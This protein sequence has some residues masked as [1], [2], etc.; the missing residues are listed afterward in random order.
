MQKN[1][2]IVLGIF[3]ILAVVLVFFQ[4]QQQNANG[5][6]ETTPLENTLEKN[7]STP[8]PADEEAPLSFE[9]KAWKQRI[10]AAFAPFNCPELLPREYPGGYYTGPL[11]DTH[12]HIPN[13]PD[14]PPEA[15]MEELRQTDRPS[16]GVNITMTEIECTLEN[17][18]TQK[19]IAF[20]PV[21]PEIPTQMVEVVNQTMQRY[22]EKFVPFIMPPAS[23][24]KPDGSPTVKAEVLADMLAIYPGLFK[25]YGEI[26]LY[27]RQGGGSKELPPDNPVLL[28]IYP[29][30]QNEKLLVYF[31]PGDGHADNLA[32][33]LDK[34]P[35]IIFLVHGD[36]IQPGIIDLMDK[37]PNVY[38]TMNDLYGDEWLLR[39]QV[40]KQEFL[41]YFSYYEPLIQKDL[42]MYEEMIEKHPDRFMWG[43]DR[44]DTL[45][46][47]DI[48]VG[49][50]LADY[51]RA[52]IGRLDPEIQEKF[53]YKNAERFLQQN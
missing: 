43:T 39:P 12:F 6:P 24:N 41:D 26:G 17:D 27:A 50:K 48:E 14:A 15:T 23:D 51:G 37:H 7:N 3:V 42:A 46:T 16:L 22:P 32:Q 38:F 8:N 47:Y 35:D 2:L 36:Q 10:D 28:E 9:E 25:G 33:V 53:A 19:V 20:F 1:I 29:I 18:G 31:H 5:Q 44:G 49:Q 45:W 21:Y 30:V 4:I 34:Y 11:I 40:T 13:I 52:F